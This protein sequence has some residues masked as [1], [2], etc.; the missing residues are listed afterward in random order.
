MTDAKEIKIRGRNVVRIT[1]R[2]GVIW[3]RGGAYLRTS[4]DICWV[5]DL[6]ADS[7]DIYSNQNWKIE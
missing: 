1:C 4:K 2:G 6:E 7:F 3:E 5:T